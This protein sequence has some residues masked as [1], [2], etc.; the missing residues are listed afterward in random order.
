[1]L[2]DRGMEGRQW[3]E[4]GRRLQEML[5]REMAL[6]LRPLLYGGCIWVVFG[7]DRAKKENEWIEQQWANGQDRKGEEGNGRNGRREKEKKAWTAGEAYLRFLELGLTRREAY[8]R[9]L[10]LGLTRREAEVAVQVCKGLCNKEIA[11]ELGISETTVKK[12]IS[13]IFEKMEVE[14]RQEIAGRLDS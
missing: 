13:N 5:M 9:F 3:A 12:H 2:S 1:M 4:S 8:L 7:N 6:N 14:R 10:E 11:M